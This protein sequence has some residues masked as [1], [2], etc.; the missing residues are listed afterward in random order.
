MPKILKLTY[1]PWINM[2][3]C[4]LI[5][6]IKGAHLDS[7]IFSAEREGLTHNFPIFSA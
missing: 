3:M 5:K 6:K 4:L 2:A 7:F 1:C